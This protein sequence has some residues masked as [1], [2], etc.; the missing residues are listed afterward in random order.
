MTPTPT[1]YESKQCTCTDLHLQRKSFLICWRVVSS[2]KRGQ[3]IIYA[4][5]LETGQHSLGRWTW[6]LLI[7]LINKHK[8]GMILVKVPGWEITKYCVSHKILTRLAMGT[9][10]NVLLLM[11]LASSRW[12][13]DLIH[14]R[15][16]WFCVCVCCF[17]PYYLGAYGHFYI[18]RE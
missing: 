8:Q 6:K 11:L 5:D 7:K 15:E 1:K 10:S 14:N 17:L 16:G 13:E 12:G 18:V 4:L 3:C 2:L 9:T